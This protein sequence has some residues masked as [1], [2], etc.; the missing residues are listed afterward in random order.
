MIE[1]GAGGYGVLPIYIAETIRVLAQR[2]DA[3]VKDCAS[4]AP[5]LWGTT[6]PLVG[7]IRPRNSRTVSG[8]ATG[9][10]LRELARLSSR[11]TSAAITFTRCL[12]MLSAGGSSRSSDYTSPGTRTTLR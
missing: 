10:A 4:S 12:P 8:P 9:S 7:H 1:V 11:A 2:S 6:V 3:T 5:K